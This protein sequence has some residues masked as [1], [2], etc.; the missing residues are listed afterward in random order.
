VTVFVVQQPQGKKRPDGSVWTPDLSS[1]EKHGA[2]RFVF[3]GGDQ[4]HLTPQDALDT[5]RRVLSSFEPE[6]DYVCW[7]SNSDPAALFAVMM[8][9]A[10]LE[11]RKLT[12]LIWDRQQGDRSK[13][14]YK[15]VT[16]QLSTY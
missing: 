9:L 3:Q 7:A 1:A 8:V 11:P 14:Y 13:G 5:A 12:F 16:F 10:E 2:I 15:P 4:P 6:T